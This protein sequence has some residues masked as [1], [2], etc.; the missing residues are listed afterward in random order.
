MGENFPMAQT[1]SKSVLHRLHAQSK[2][3]EESGA[4]LILRL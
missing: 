3:N 1:I 4:T 2:I